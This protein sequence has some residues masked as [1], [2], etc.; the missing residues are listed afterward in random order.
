MLP[1]D[2]IP[3]TAINYLDRGLAKE[4]LGEK[5]AAKADFEEAARINGDL[6]KDYYKEGR[7]KNDGQAY[8]AAMAS[9][10][11]AIRLN[12]EY[13]PVYSNRAISQNALGRP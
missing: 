10:D 1:S 4:V 13:A 12:P 8:T 3:E 7:G 2:S 11:K 6:A 5:S 9:F